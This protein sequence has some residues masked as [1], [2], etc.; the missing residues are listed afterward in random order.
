MEY[1]RYLRSSVSDRLFMET[2][3]SINDQKVQTLH[4]D[5]NQQELIQALTVN[6]M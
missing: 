1:F 6:L 2:N 3:Q 4:L 5:T